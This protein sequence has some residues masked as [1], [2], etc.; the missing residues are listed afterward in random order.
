MF[1][2]TRLAIQ[3]K[4]SEQSRVKHSN[5]QLSDKQSCHLHTKLDNQNIDHNTTF[6]KVTKNKQLLNQ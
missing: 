1:S 2:I 5:Q 3:R 6:L 4:D